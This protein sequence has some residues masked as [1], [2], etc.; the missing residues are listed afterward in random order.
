MDQVDF[1]QIEESIHTKSK[2]GRG[3]YKQYFDKGRLII[4]KY[5]SE[6][7]PTAAVRKFKKDFANINESIVRGFCKR[8][9]KEIAQAKKDQRRTATILPTQ[10][11]G[12]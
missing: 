6:N 4:G 3:K 2:T 12:H 8:Y 1:D 7:G 11:R 9:D 5:T 10:K